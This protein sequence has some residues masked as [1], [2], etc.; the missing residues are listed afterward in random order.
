MKSVLLSLCVLFL[1]IGCNSS[2]SKRLESP[3]SLTTEEKRELSGY[4]H[5]IARFSNSVSNPFNWGASPKTMKAW[6]KKVGWELESPLTSNPTKPGV[7]EMI[8]WIDKGEGEYKQRI[9]LFF[10]HNKLASVS[11]M[12]MGKMDRAIQTILD[13][14]YSLLSPGVWRNIPSK[15]TVQKQTSPSDV[16]SMYTFVDSNQ[17]S[18]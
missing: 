3:E 14:D 7:E 17:L 6:G 8:Y 2:S 1:A 13:E 5:R 10:Y 12:A 18:Q 4:K 11:I 16:A 15:A 9:I